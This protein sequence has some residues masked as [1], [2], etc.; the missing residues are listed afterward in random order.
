MFKSLCL[1]AGLVFAASTAAQ[2]CSPSFPRCDESGRCGSN[3]RAPEW[4]KPTDLTKNFDIIAVV[5]AKVNVETI[6]TKNPRN[7]QKV[8]AELTTLRTVKGA[9]ETTF[10][11]EHVTQGSASDKDWRQDPERRFGLWDHMNLKPKYYTNYGSASCQSRHKDK[12]LS[13]QTYLVF[14]NGSDPNYF[15][16]DAILLEGEDDVLVDEIEAI[17]QDHPDAPNRMDAKTYVQNMVGFAEFTLKECPSKEDLSYNDSR[18]VTA[19]GQ[20]NIAY[21]IDTSL[22]YETPVIDTRDLAN[23]INSKNDVRKQMQDFRSKLWRDSIHLSATDKQARID[24]KQTS[25]SHQCLVNDKYLAIF[26][27]PNNRIS[28]RYLPIENGTID[29]AQVITN[30]QLTGPTRINVSDVEAWIKEANFED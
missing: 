2:A 4:I 22:N 29:L 24:E 25:L 11:I 30:I 28:F 8:T 12:F 9:P 6:E 16:Q 17:A 23:Y 3:Y 21:N 5:S 20:H 13:G 19:K 1:A 14:L 7:R 10:K 18:F 26:R 27:R 15:I